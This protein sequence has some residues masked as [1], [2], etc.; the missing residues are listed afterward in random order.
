[1][2][3]KKGWEKGRSER[4]EAGKGMEGRQRMGAVALPPR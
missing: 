2:R 3:E 1:L 4:K